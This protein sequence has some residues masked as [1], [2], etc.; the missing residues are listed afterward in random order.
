VVG[1]LVLAQLQSQCSAVQSLRDRIRVLLDY[2]VDV[3]RG[4]SV[5]DPQ[6]LLIRTDPDPHLRAH[7]DACVCSTCTRMLNPGG[8][9]VVA[10]AVAADPALLRAVS[11]VCHRLPLLQTAALEDEAHQVPSLH[12][13]T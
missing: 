8:L 9:V 3:E 7:T 13:H 2:L 5:P 6:P 11:A 12:S 10:G 4:M 1:N